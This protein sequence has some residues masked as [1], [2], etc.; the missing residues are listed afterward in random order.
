MCKFVIPLEL[1]FQF[2]DFQEDCVLIQALVVGGW[3]GEWA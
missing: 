1:G 3:V 2:L